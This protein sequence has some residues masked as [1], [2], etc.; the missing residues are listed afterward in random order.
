L[1]WWPHPDNYKPETEDRLVKSLNEILQVADD[2][3]IDIVLETQ[4]TTTLNSP[5]TIK[6]VIEC[7]GSMR[8]KFNLAPCNFVSDLQIAY[9]PKPMINELF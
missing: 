7:T 6:R 4:V 9:D 3:D 8:L 2:H 1:D 5:A